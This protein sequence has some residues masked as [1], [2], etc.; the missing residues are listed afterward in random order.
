M[1]KEQ[2]IEILEKRIKRYHP[3]DSIYEA[4]DIAISALRSQ[5]KQE[6]P[7]PLTLDELMQRNGKPVFVVCGDK[8]DDLNGWFIVSALIHTIETP[9][10]FDVKLNLELFNAENELCP[11]QDFYGMTCTDLLREVCSN[12]C[13]NGLHKLGWMAYDN[14]P[15][16]AQS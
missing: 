3:C 12:D 5:Q 6:N 4:M 13:G 8:N 16:K 14:E 2:A 10:V 9:K 7:Q 1:D 15:N 11:D